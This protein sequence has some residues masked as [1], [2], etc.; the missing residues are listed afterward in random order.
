[1]MSKQRADGAYVRLARNSEIPHLALTLTRA[2]ARDPAMNWYG[3]V[4]KLVPSHNSTTRS[5]IDTMRRLSY[6][7][8]FLVR[9]TLLIGGIISVVVRPTVT[10]TECNEGSQP[11]EEQIIA[12]A[13]WLKPGQSWNLGVCVKAGVLK[14][15]LFGWGISGFNRLARIFVPNVDAVLKRAFDSR[16]LDSLDSWY[17]LEIVTDPDEQGKGYCSMLMRDGFTRT[18]PKPVHLEATTSASRDIYLRFGFEVEEET[19]FGK[20]KV[21]D[22]GVRVAKGEAAD[23]C[24]EWIMIKWKY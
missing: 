8:E 18:A 9:A 22:N 6:F 4:K 14:A 15:L 17:L 11:P 24:R 13:M 19:R 3:G 16:D 12:L 23:G 5:A 7:Q 2:F 21:D 10:C 20:G 1:M